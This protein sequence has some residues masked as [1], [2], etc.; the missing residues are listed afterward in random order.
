MLV[1]L[2]EDDYD[3]HI[4]RQAKA[5]GLAPEL[6]K[7]VIWK[8]SRFQA[9]QLG[10]KGELG[11]MQLLKPAIEDWCKATKRPYPSREE[12]LK[13]E[14]NIEIGAWYLAWCGKRF[15]DYRDQSGLVIQLAIYNAGYGRVRI[16]LREQPEK[17]V[18]TLEDISFPTTRDYI[19]Q[20]LERKAYYQEK[21]DF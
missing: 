12:L 20:I 21:H 5:H 2:H 17:K 10:S 14:L 7:A 13:P 8:E 16:W 1:C 19:N 15:P 4:L 9:D 3:A 11:L 18:F 6:L